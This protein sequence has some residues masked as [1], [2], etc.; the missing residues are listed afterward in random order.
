[1]VLGSIVVLGVEEV[2]GG[3]EENRGQ[4]DDV[5]EEIGEVAARVLS[6]D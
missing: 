1:M 3:S 6:E 5:L 4:S 2:E